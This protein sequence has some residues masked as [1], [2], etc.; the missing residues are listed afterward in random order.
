VSEQAISPSPVRVADAVAGLAQGVLVVLAGA[1][2]G[3]LADGRHR[4]F[5]GRGSTFGAA[6]SVP[7]ALSY[8]RAIARAA[9]Y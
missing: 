1:A 8:G 4:R 9:P 2:I 3:R 6:V 5:R 7:I